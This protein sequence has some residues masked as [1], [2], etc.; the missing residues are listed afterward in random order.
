MVGSTIVN[1]ALLNMGLNR[2]VSFVSTLCLFAV[3]NFFALRW[4][5]AKSEAKDSGDKKKKEKKPS[6]KAKDSSN[7]KDIHEFVKSTG[8]PVK[9]D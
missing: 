4:L 9:V 6:S 5:V 1:A 8:K 7:K 2:T 3:V